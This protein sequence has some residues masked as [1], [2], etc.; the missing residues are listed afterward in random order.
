[1]NEA[2]SLLKTASQWTIAFVLTIVL[3]LFFVSIAAAQVTSEGAGRRV[4]RRSVAVTTNID[5][6]LPGIE[7][8]LHEAANE[9]GEAQVRV[10][11]FPI[12]VDI[13]RAEAATISGA[14]LRARILDESARR[15]YD[16]GMSAWD[17]GDPEARQDVERISTAGLLHMGLGTIRDSNHTIFLGLAGVFGVLALGLAAALAVSLS[18]YVRLI[19]LGGVTVAASLMVL[20]AAVAV[21]FGFRTAESEADPFA[22]GMLDLGVDVMEVPIRSFLTLSVLGAAV[23]LGASVFLWWESR[24]ATRTAPAYTDPTH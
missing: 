5:A 18:P 13:P 15:L 16:D 14:E 24:S 19:A 4:L 7:D 10:P 6:V 2:R 8:K 12:A 20:A 22:K 3:I 1:M 23:A 17:S 11:D 21:R 9:S